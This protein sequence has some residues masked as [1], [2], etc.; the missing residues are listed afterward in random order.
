MEELLEA[1]KPIMPVPWDDKLD[2]SVGGAFFDILDIIID[3][4]FP[5]LN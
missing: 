3:Q 4:L 5:K 2:I 1:T